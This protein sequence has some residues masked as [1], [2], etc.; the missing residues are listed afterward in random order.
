MKMTAD[1]F[2][3]LPN[4]ER[5]RLV[6][7]EVE[8]RRVARELAEPESHARWKASQ[9]ALSKQQPEAPSQG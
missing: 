3:A 6:K 9:G 5:M 7:A 2:W 1:E 8:A 4:E